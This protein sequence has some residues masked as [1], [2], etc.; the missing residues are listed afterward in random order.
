MVKV[1]RGPP[2]AAAATLTRVRERAS[3]SEAHYGWSGRHPTSTV[4]GGNCFFGPL[5]QCRGRSHEARG[6]FGMTECRRAAM[7]DESGPGTPRTSKFQRFLWIGLVIVTL[8]FVI[9]SFM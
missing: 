2:L 3:L 1:C 5:S 6:A 9:L 8:V 4:V 7:F